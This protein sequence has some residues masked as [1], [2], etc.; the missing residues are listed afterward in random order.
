MSTPSFDRATTCCFSGYRPHKYPFPFASG[1]AEYNQLESD[2]MNAILI[3][4]REGY[5]TFLCGGAM[6]FD[7]LCGEIVLLAKQQL[8]DIR[9]VCVLPFEGQAGSFPYDWAA[10][11]RKVLDASD[12]ITYVSTQY[13]ARCYLKRNEAM[14]D[15]SARVITYFDGKGG[16][17]ARTISYAQRQ[18]LDI[19]NLCKTDP[20][21]EQVTFFTGYTSK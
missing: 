18:K 13:T 19:V 8:P 21:P 2:I 15:A 12:A 9:L 11:Y 5:R 10:R 4:Y 20:T 6:G 1:N 14:I 17:T 16:G 7:L 3:S